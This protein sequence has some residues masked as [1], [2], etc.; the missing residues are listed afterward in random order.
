MATKQ[1][2]EQELEDAYAR[3][4]ELESY[5]A[6]GAEVLGNEEDAGDD[7]EAEE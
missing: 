7:D 1:Q 2:V 5:I 6:Q 3:I 4:D